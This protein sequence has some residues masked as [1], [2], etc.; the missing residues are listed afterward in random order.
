M[1]FSLILHRLLHYL[2]MPLIA[3]PVI[4]LFCPI[5]RY[6][7]P[8]HFYVLVVQMFGINFKNF[9]SIHKWIEHDRDRLSKKKFQIS[10]EQ[11]KYL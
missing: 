2:L 8:E 1:K 9:L 10:Q 7:L 6:Y 11:I 3:F 5:S 4:H